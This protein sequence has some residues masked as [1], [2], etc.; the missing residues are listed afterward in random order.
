MNR[1][2][3]VAVGM[4]Q[5]VGGKLRGHQ[6]GHFDDLARL[7][8]EDVSDESARTGHGLGPA[9]KAAGLRHGST[10]NRSER[11]E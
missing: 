11:P 4:S 2:L 6:L 5:A 8:A 3:K 10:E 1:Q 9:V 7:L